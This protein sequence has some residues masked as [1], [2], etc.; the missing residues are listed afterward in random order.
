MV[1]YGVRITEFQER[2]IPIGRTSPIRAIAPQHCLED[3][4][5]TMGGIFLPNISLLGG[6]AVIY[7]KVD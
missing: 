5:Y 2:E 1:S 7:L 6:C 4:E 3:S